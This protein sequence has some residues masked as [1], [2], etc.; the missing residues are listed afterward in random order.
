METASGRVLDRFFE[1]WIYGSE[2]PRVSYSSSI[3]DGDV[4]VRF[5]QQGDLIFDLPVTVSLDYGGGRTVDVMVPVTDR[6]V[7]RT[8]PTDG[9]VRRVRINEDHAALAEFDGR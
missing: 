7:E 1:R 9:A 2:I 4:T 8:I 3:A 5:E 6:E